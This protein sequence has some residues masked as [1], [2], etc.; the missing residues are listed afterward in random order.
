M[1]PS[2]CV[3]WRRRSGKRGAPHVFESLRIPHL[4]AGQQGTPDAYALRKQLHLRKYIFPLKTQEGGKTK[5]NATPCKRNNH[6]YRRR[7]DDY[8]HDM[9]SLIFPLPVFFPIVFC[10]LVVHPEPALGSSVE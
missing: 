6:H 5:A 1:R 2:D 3:K 8:P 7:K 4:D 10:S 9:V